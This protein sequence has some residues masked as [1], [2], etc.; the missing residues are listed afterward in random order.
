[1]CDSLG[2]DPQPC[3]PHLLPVDLQT[4]DLSKTHASLLG[5]WL[6]L[7][8]IVYVIEGVSGVF[9]KPGQAAKCLNLL[10]ATG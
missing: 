6:K 5:F 7:R 4:R 9:E 2:R 1:M 8:Q 10:T 3:F